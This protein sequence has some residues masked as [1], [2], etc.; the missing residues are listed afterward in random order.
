M[1]S[2]NFKD[3]CQ[4]VGRYCVFSDHASHQN[5]IELFI[6][7]VRALRNN[8]TVS[9]YIFKRWQPPI[10]ADYGSDTAKQEFFIR[11]LFP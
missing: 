7:I 2:G 9:R 11:L 6:P 10:E 8:L 3:N 1:E 5:S 4:P